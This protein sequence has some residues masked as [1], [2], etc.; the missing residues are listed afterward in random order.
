MRSSLR[1]A[2]GV[3]AVLGGLLMATSVMA[4]QGEY[5]V[6]SHVVSDT[7]I[8]STGDGGVGDASG[9]VVSGD[10][11]SAM[12]GGGSGREYGRPDLFYNYYT[13]GYANQAN[14]QMYI[15]PVPVP[16]YVGHTFYTYQPLMP[17]HM[18]YHH[19]DRY[20]NH[21]DGG[22]GTNRTMV[23]YGGRTA[24]DFVDGLFETIGRAR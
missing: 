23:R 1:V 13:Q 21:Y 4:Q 24:Y 22:R 2:A 6:G 3:A 15:S 5:I 8:S 18:L 9:T 14:A 20:H 12:I 17:H 16:Y 10:D 19:T 7:V 11:G